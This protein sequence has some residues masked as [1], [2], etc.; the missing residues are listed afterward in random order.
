MRACLWSYDIGRLDQEDDKKR[1][2]TNVLNHGTKNATDWLTRTYTTNDI[3]E[4][5]AKPL[6]GEW[7]AKSLN[8]WS[9]VYGAHP[10]D[11]ARAL[12]TSHARL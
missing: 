1:I 9:L 2:I 5:I 8:L 4:A 11:G 10:S 3:V 6:S 12:R 7:D